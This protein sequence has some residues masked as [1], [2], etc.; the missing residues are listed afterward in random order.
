[1]ATLGLPAFE[2]LLVG[3]RMETDIRMGLEA[4]MRTALVLTGITTRSDLE[5][6][7]YKPD[8]VLNDLWEMSLYTREWNS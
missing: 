8:I 3:D 6:I 4:G 1:L 7:V 2:C 5:S